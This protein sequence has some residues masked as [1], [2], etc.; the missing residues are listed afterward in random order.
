[1]RVV[2]VDVGLVH[3]AIVVLSGDVEGAIALEEMRLVNI[4]R[5]THGRV[6]EYDCVLPHTN[7]I[8]DRL[9]HFWQEHGD[10]F[11]EAD[12]VAV[13]QQPPMGLVAVEAFLMAK[14]RAVCEIVSPR[15]LHGWVFGA[16]HGK[17]YEQRKVEM[18]MHAA[19]LCTR[20]SGDPTRWDRATRDLPR[21]HD[22]ADALAI[23]WY[24]FARRRALLLHGGEAPT[25]RFH[26]G[27]RVSPHFGG[28]PAGAKGERMWSR[29]LDDFPQ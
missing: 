19:A 23:A 29:V 16:R 15:A 11:D 8:A 21:R 22:V 26:A 14:C 17:D 24:A 27:A 20:L 7:H 5:F 6:S 4:T 18:E 13:E 9:A 2:G 10:L 28:W 1:M 25:P 3:L 12:L